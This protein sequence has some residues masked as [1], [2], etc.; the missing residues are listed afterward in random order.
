[1]GTPP[2]APSQASS[3]EPQKRAWGPPALCAPHSVSEAFSPCLPQL[4][5][6]SLS[7]APGAGRGVGKGLPLCL[8]KG[9]F[10]A[11]GFSPGQ[12][13]CMHLQQER[14]V[15]GGGRD[16]SVTRRGGKDTR[17]LGKVAAPCPCAARLS[18]R[19][20]ERPG[21]T[22]GSVFCSCRALWAF[23]A[24][25]RAQYVRKAHPE[26]GMGRETRWEGVLVSPP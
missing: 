2:P 13:R 7:A 22:P 23:R 17:C 16:L 20:L 10:S 18:P 26:E 19:A 11:N 21:L 12:K 5:P 4:G 6:P 8:A 24:D 9:S 3:P 25:S 1:M 15:P 14:E